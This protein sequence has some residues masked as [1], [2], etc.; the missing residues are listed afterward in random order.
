M[1]EPNS[2]AVQRLPECSSADQRRKPLRQGRP[3]NPL[4]RSKQGER[5]AGNPHASVRRG[6]GLETWHGRD[7]VTLP[8][9][10][11]RDNRE[12]KLRPKL[13]RQSPTLPMRGSGNGATVEPLRHRQTKEAGT[14]MPSLTPPRHIPTLRI[15]VV[16]CVV[17]ARQQSPKRSPGASRRSGFDPGGQTA[18]NRQNWVTCRISHFEQVKYCGLCR[19]CWDSRLRP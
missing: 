4:G 16:H 3:H 15:A 5:S 2:E 10:K 8:Q 9:P 14:D 7:G 11:E 17:L 18:K 1:A 13:A 12:H 6:G 19:A